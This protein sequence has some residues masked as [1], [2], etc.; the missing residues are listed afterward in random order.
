MREIWRGVGTRPEI[1]GLHPSIAAEVL[2]CAGVL[3]GWIGS[4]N[5]IKEADD[6]ARDL[7]TESITLFESF[8]DLKKIAEAQT[9]LAYCYWRAGALDEARIMFSEALQQL[10][11]EGRTRANALLGLSVVEWSD[12]R[13]DEALKT[14]T[15][16]A[17]LFAKL[18]SHTLK[19][20]YH[21]QLAMIFRNLATDKTKADYF[22]KA[23]KEY[24]E[25]DNQF[26]LAC[27]TVF[28]AHVKN[29]LGF[30]LYK[31]SRFRKAHE[32]LNQARRLTV[33]VRDKVRTAQVDESR[34]QVFIAQRR[35]GSA[36]AAARNAA[37]SFE[38]AG[39]QAF[40]A[41]ALITQGIAIA[42]LR[43]PERARFIFQ[44]A[45]EIAHQA[46]VLNRAGLAALTMIEEIESLPP[47]ILIAAY[48]QAEVWLA[49]CQSES[50]RQRLELAAK[51]MPLESAQL[52]SET[53]TELLYNKRYRL[54]EEVTKYEREIIR[55]TLAQANGSITASAR[56]LGMSYQRLASIISRR[57]PELLKLRTP[58]RRRAQKKE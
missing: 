39:R 28:R 17:A 15:E 18:H 40:L 13:Y 48:Q 19:G 23:V 3:T 46:G 26:K 44:K 58:V 45:I 11:T 56:M 21:N 20:Y 51:K 25:A 36:E 32:Y 43:K 5:E 2:L 14:L 38:R 29:N 9:E 42:R 12:S 1:T 52:S 41:E 57:H 55:S 31:L 22:G 33:S 24:E 34:A 47:E 53:A 6:H 10:T 7:L 27:N 4:R 54:T 49:D 30:L 8:G 50:I 37:I 16:N 35:Y